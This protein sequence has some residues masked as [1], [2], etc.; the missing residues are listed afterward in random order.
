MRKSYDLVKIS[1]LD[2]EA[3]LKTYVF[4]LKPHSDNITLVL[5]KDG[6]DNYEKGFYF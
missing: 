4:T 1:S 3:L 5:N 2:T 6:V